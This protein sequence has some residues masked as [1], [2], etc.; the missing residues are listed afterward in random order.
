MLAVSIDF[1]SGIIVGYDANSDTF[2]LFVSGPR[3]GISG[4]AIGLDFCT[5]AFEGDLRTPMDISLFD[6]NH[7][8]PTTWGT[9]I[10]DIPGDNGILCY[11]RANIQKQGETTVYD[12]PDHA[13]CHKINLFQDGTF[14]R[15]AELG[16]YPG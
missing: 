11:V 13:Q 6:V 14:T 5:Q 4:E 9:T 7:N 10:S 16:S 1:A 12:P 2:G 3:S 15:A 8:G